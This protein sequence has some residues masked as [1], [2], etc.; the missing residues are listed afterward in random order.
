MMRY[1]FA[2]AVD[3]NELQERFDGNGAGGP[4]RDYLWYAE[5]LFRQPMPMPLEAPPADAVEMLRE[6]VE[7]PEAQRRARFAGLLGDYA[8]RL[9]AK[10]HVVV[11]L[12]SPGLWP[13]RIRMFRDKLRLAKW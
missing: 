11:N 9:R 13:K 5:A 7:R 12:L 4:L 10:P 1:R 8:A 2:S 3:W 6:A